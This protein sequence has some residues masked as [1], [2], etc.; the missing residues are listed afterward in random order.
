MFAGH[1]GFGG[2]EAWVIP[3]VNTD[4]A[5]GPKENERLEKKRLHFVHIDIFML[6]FYTFQE[7]GKTDISLSRVSAQ[8]GNRKQEAL[9]QNS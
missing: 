7:Q 2:T 6:H 3:A 8:T 4:Q 9:A 5:K 1:G